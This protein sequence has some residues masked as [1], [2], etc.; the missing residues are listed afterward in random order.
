MAVQGDGDLKLSFFCPT[1]EENYEISR[2]SNDDGGKGIPG[3]KISFYNMQYQ[4]HGDHTI[5]LEFENQQLVN[6]QIV[7]RIYS[8]NEMFLEDNIRCSRIVNHLLESKDFTYTSGILYLVSGQSYDKFVTGLAKKYLLLEDTVN[9]HFEPEL[10]FIQHE[11]MVLVITSYEFGSKYIRKGSSMIKSLNLDGE[12]KLRS[13][14]LDTSV[15]DVDYAWK[16]LKKSKLNSDVRVILAFDTRKNNS[17][18]IDLQEKLID[19]FNLKSID[20]LNYQ[21]TNGLKSI[22]LQS[23]YNVLDDPSQGRE[24][25]EIMEY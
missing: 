10:M 3:P 6:H 4:D 2:K 1:C 11:E 12:F 13:L 21:D 22:F 16:Y 24:V 23:Y 9:I 5:F 20:L 18:P 17:P 14:V 25:F 7:N 15:I 8:V 19:R